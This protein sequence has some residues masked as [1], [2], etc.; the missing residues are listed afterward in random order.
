MIGTCSMGGTAGAAGAGGTATATGAGGVAADGDGAAGFVGV[1]LQL[2]T[3]IA[4]AATR[5]TKVRRDGRR[6]CWLI[7]FSPAA[8][9]Q[10]SVMSCNK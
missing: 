2:V 10:G 5:T 6:R 8:L 4:Q 1:S 3:T 7:R 9:D